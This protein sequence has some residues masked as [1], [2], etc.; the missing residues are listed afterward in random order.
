MPSRRSRN[1]AHRTCADE[2][3]PAD[4][5]AA[6]ESHEGNGIKTAVK[7]TDFFRKHKVITA[8]MG[9]YTAMFVAAGTYMKVTGNALDWAGMIFLCPL[10]L[11]IAAGTYKSLRTH[12]E[13]YRSIRPQLLILCCVFT[14]G[15]CL[16]ES[17]RKLFAV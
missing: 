10:L 5:H 15:V 17:L 3:V 13:K 7:G 16:L 11:G 1:A 14:S 4:D 8:V 6:A 12:P 2:H 9:A